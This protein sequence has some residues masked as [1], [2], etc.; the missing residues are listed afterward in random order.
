LRRILTLAFALAL[1]AAPNAFAIGSANSGGGGGKAITDRVAQR[2]TYPPPSGPGHSPRT[3]AR[4]C[5]K[6]KVCPGH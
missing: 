1:I 6:G 3:A 2:A 4:H 5:A